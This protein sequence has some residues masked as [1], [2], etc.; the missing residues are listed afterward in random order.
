MERL[1][2]PRND[3]RCTT[4]VLNLADFEKSIGTRLHGVGAI[5]IPVPE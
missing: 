4:E 2:A 3:C 1:R 5:G